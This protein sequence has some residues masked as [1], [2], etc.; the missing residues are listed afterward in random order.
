[1]AGGKAGNVIPQMAE[2][3]GTTRTFDPVVRDLIEA[4]VTD[5]AEKVAEAYGA[6]ARVTY[7]RMFSADREPCQRNRLRC[8]CGQIIG[9]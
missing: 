4:R 7:K 2:M 3:G 1:M 9:R 5:I 6:K 8:Q